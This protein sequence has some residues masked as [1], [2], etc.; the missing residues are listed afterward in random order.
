MSE[1]VIP[2][3][4]VPAPLPS[5][6]G[7]PPVVRFELSLKSLFIVL[8]VI[9]GVLLL[10][11]LLPALLVLMVALMIVGAVHPLVSWL[12]RHQMRRSLAV[13]VVFA[14]GAALTVTLL[15][16]TVPTVIAQVKV[17]A[18]HEPG[19]REKIAGYL[20]GHALT[21][22][23]ADNL[24]DMRYGEL[25]SSSR[26]ALVILSTRVIEIV[27]YAVAA[28]FLAFYIAL[29]RDRLRG[30]LFAVVPRRHH[31]RLSRIL[32]NLGTIVGGFL[33]GQILLCALMTGFLLALLLLCGV[34]NALAIALFGG[35]MDLLPYLG[36]FL[37]MGPAVL[38]ALAVGPTVAL[39]VF[40]MLLAY[41]EFES[42]ALIP[43]IYGRV[44]R[45]PS[46]V[47]FF[48][49][50]LGTTLAGIAGALFAL[51]I[52]A[53]VLMLVEELRLE[54]PGETVQ[55]EDIAQRRE[56]NRSEEEY[57]RRAESMPAEKAAA[58]AVKISGDRK[59]DEVEAAASAKAAPK[60]PASS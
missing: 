28:V 3:V 17:L 31:I 9:A 23:L 38:A 42:R 47:V 24:R 4:P 52:A 6:R 51:P 46:S 19:I 11:N 45:L 37:T 29:D 15:T 16:L 32:I 33:R 35:L 10:V 40:V 48:S 60:T 44:L 13:F 43:L 36:I 55:P 34:P 25:V 39:V 1:P 20:E 59:K 53:A 49:L 22:A 18:S 27:A 54:L 14:I 57:E 41:E 30:V 7:E 8:A 58:I 2:P 5:D 12:E 26:S 21:A 56:D 50:I